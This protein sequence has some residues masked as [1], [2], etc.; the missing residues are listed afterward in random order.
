MT[1]TIIYFIPHFPQDEVII[2][3]ELAGAS[4][5]QIVGPDTE[6][7]QNIAFVVNA[8]NPPKMEHG[9]IRQDYLVDP[10][11]EEDKWHLR[12]RAAKMMTFVGCRKGLTLV[13]IADQKIISTFCAIE[14]ILSGASKKEVENIEKFGASS[15]KIIKFEMS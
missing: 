1:N 5:D 10:E 13:I 15:Q 9:I 4:I 8:A 11:K 7:G 2:R 3:Q 12:D 6:I 14:A